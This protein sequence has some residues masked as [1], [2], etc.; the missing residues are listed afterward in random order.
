MKRY[1]TEI[2]EKVIQQIK[3]E[4]ERN[5]IFGHLMFFL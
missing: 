2:L 5:E 4:Q 3:E 1:A